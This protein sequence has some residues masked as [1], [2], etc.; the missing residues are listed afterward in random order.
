MVSQA[1]YVYRNANVRVVASIQVLRDRTS[2]FESA[3]ASGIQAGAAANGY[4]EVWN[5]TPIHYL[6]SPSTTSSTTYKTQMKVETT[7][8]GAT[9]RCQAS[10]P[11]GSGQSTITLIEV[12]A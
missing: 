3:A 9:V 4:S 12:S 11:D 7:A 10:E 8:N 2:I 5:Q 6:D 1:N